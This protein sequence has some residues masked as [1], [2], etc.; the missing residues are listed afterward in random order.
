MIVNIKENKMV[1]V[2][3][4]GASGLVGSKIREI[5]EERSIRSNKIH[6]I[7]NWWKNPC[8]NT[9]AAADFS[10]K[11]SEIKGLDGP[12]VV[13][14]YYN[15]ATKEGLNLDFKTI[16]ESTDLP[17]ILYTVWSWWNYWNKTPSRI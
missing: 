14:P 17:I 11:V 10:K 1:N 16:A 4:V 2:A 3:V 6:S 7:E 5:L 13:T 15:K 12:L 9:R 8:N